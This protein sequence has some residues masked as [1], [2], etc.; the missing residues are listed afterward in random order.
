MEAEKK[1]V[2]DPDRKD[3]RTDQACGW[4]ERLEVAKLPDMN[5]ALFDFDLLVLGYISK[6]DKISVEEPFFMVK[7]KRG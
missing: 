1:A 7:R 6:Y 2:A 5:Q 3:T 4:S